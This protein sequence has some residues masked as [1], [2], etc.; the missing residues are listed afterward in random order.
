MS[1]RSAYGH[2]EVNRKNITFTIGVIPMFPVLTSD[3]GG[4]NI[5]P[6][7]ELL[8]LRVSMEYNS[9]VKERLLLVQEK[10]VKKWTRRSN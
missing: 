10:S 3:L 4:C 1:A 8:Q 6:F 2:V 7:K 5:L 9:T